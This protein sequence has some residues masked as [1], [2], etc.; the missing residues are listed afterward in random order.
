MATLGLILALLSACLLIPTQGSLIPADV[1]QPRN[2][3]E[4]SAVDDNR[5][6]LQALAWAN[7]QKRGS[8]TYQ[9][10]ESIILDRSWQ[11]ELIW[12][13]YV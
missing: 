7:L 10:D 6:D 8:G 5:A 11:N 2:E 12:N 1:V 13:A 9:R 4:R 3:I